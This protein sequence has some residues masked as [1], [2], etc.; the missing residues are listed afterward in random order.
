MASL[1]SDVGE[2]VFASCA[3][4]ASWVA[5]RPHLRPEL[6][7][8]PP[9][10]PDS[11]SP[12]VNVRMTADVALPHPWVQ[13]NPSVRSFMRLSEVTSIPSDIGL[14]HHLTSSR[15]LNWRSLNSRSLGSR[16]QGS[17]Y[18]GSRSLGRTDSLAQSFIL[19]NC[20]HDSYSLSRSLFL[21]YAASYLYDIQPYPTH[22]W[23]LD[24]RD[25]G[26]QLWVELINLIKCPQI[27][28]VVDKP[29]SVCLR[30]QVR[31]A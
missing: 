15:S 2:V 26:S 1:R 31:H 11:T 21:Q 13:T 3:S 30:D 9:L 17:R 18:L 14:H 5:L 6:P 28:P 24:S 22:S 12:L 4:C 8:N 7:S 20:S 27:D 19:F 25:S 16:S 10:H 23:I 29:A